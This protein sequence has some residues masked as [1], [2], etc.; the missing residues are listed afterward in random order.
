VPIDNG[1]DRRS[2]CTTAPARDIGSAERDLRNELPEKGL[3]HGPVSEN[4]A[5]A[6]AH[7]N[8]LIINGH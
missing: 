6:F 2:A 1:I 5:F 7:S 8:D 3:M 4:A